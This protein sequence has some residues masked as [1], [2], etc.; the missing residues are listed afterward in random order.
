[1]ADQVF[2]A[3]FTDDERR[4]YRQCSLNCMKNYTPVVPTPDVYTCGPVGSWDPPSMYKRFTLPP[5]GSKLYF[6]NFFSSSLSFQVLNKKSEKFHWLKSVNCLLIKFMLWE[7]MNDFVAVPTEINTPTRR[8]IATIAYE[9]PSKEC[10]YLRNELARRMT[11]VLM[12]E[13]SAWSR[14]LCKAPDCS[15]IPL[16]ISCHTNNVGGQKLQVT[17]PT[18]L[19]VSLTIDN[20]P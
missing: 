6:K 4:G 7:E 14:Q 13:N 5:C 1:M 9:V 11:A 8:V 15:D 10:V 12:T 18:N 20:A 17:H 19:T 3:N 2:C 16:D